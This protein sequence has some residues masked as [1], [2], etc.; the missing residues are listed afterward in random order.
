[1]FATSYPDTLFVAI[2][3]LGAGGFT[4]LTTNF[5]LSLLTTMP[6]FVVMAIQ[7]FS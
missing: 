1:M 2:P 6:G 5:Q 4:L 3:A 7:V